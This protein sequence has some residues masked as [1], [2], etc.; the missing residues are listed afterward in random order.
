MG[1]IKFVSLLVC[2][3]LVGILFGF[4]SQLEGQ[5][6]GYIKDGANNESLIGVNIY[7]PE[8]QIGSST[9][10]FGYFQLSTTLPKIRLQ[11]SYVGYQTVDTTLQVNAAQ[12]V[13]ISLR[14]AA[15][16]PEVE[17]V[18]S[19]G[20]GEG[21]QLGKTVI[22]MEQ[23]NKIPPLLGEADPFKALALTPGISNGAEGTSDIYVRGGTPDQNL[24][25]YDGAKV[26]NA[27]HLFGFLSPFN[28]DIVKDIKVYKGAFPTRYGGRLSSIIDISGREGNKKQ[29]VRKLT[30]GLVNSRLLLEGP[31]IKN[32]WSYTFGARTAH[33][34][35]LLLL[36][37][38]EEDYQTYFFYDLNGKINY[39]SDKSN[40]SLSAYSSWD[41]WG[42]IDRGSEQDSKL[43]AI[44]GNRTAS[45]RYAR[46]LGS[47]LFFQGLVTYNRY[48]YG[49]E[50]ELKNESTSNADIL[51]QAFIREW[52]AKAEVDYRIH[53]KWDLNAGLEGGL[54]QVNPRSVET[55]DR[56]GGTSQTAVATTRILRLAPFIESRYRFTRD[57]QFTAGGR[58]ANFKTISGTDYTFLEPRLSLDYQVGAYQFKVAYAQMH[59]PLHLLTGNFIGI[60]NNIWVG[61]TDQAPPQAVVHYSL[62]AERKIGNTI[63]ASA[64]VYFK[65]Y[66][67]LIDPLP[68]VDF[69]QSNVG[70]WEDIVGLD[71]IGEAMG[72]ELFLRYRGER[73]FGWI[74]YTLSSSRVQFNQINE[75]EWYFR[76]YDRRHDLSLTAG[77]DIGD[78][79]EFLSTF[80]LSSGYRLTLPVSLYYDPQ[81]GAPVPVYRSRNNERT[82]IYHRLDIAFRYHRTRP[83]G[84]ERIFN[85][86]IYNAY[87]RKNPFYVIAEPD[88]RYDRP[89]DQDNRKLLI[90]N[91]VKLRSFFNFLPFVNYT[92]TF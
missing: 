23:L 33:L 83:S 49:I 63:L 13:T 35:S 53:T 75:G 91:Q 19:K 89:S 17:I 47:R 87:A 45:V 43:N 21:I 92:F 28:P 22:P 81:Y 61:A 11:I 77:Y 34:A 65:N 10:N 86:G 55:S 70:Q 41:N 1:L 9:N 88:L 76:T 71:G 4:V 40:L 50:Q 16:L 85:I 18:S 68:G 90:G 60:S 80:V 46:T 64:E 14:R 69:L 67:R 52:D 56:V 31:I 37:R 38:R 82:P 59:Q 3:H 58:L 12:P 79:W 30:L 36:A 72:I 6:Y 51:S 44:W 27:N 84:K 29:A 20:I 78:H 74:G 48:S 2:F 7:V 26:Y 62:G 39:K 32:K 24:V 25:L 66:S 57:L 8:L 73:L 5:V 15:S 54:L 42:V